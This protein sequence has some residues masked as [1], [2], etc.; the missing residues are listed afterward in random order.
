MVRKQL[1][2]IAAVLKDASQ[3]ATDGG[4]M[5]PEGSWLRGVLSCSLEGGSWLRSDSRLVIGLLLVNRYLFS[6][7]H[8]W[9]LDLALDTV[10]SKFLPW[11]PTF[12][13][14]G[15]GTYGGAINPFTPNPGDILKAKGRRSAD[16]A[17]NAEFESSNV[18]GVSSSF[19]G[20]RESQSL[21]T[22]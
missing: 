22:W 15:V 7:Y 14:G 16:R 11:M 5:G 13:A 18:A 4:V 3:W 8:V 21:V 20:I 19:W 9:A 17:E 1:L 6:N 10:V 12:Q 2:G